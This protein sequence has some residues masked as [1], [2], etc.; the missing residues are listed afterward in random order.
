MKTAW[1]SGL[2]LLPVV[3]EGDDI[4][5]FPCFHRFILIF[6]LYILPYSPSIGVQVQR[7]VGEWRT[8]SPSSIALVRACV[9]ACAC[10]C[11]VAKENWFSLAQR[12]GFCL[13]E[14]SGKLRGYGMRR[15]NELGVVGLSSIRHEGGGQSSHGLHVRGKDSLSLCRTK[16]VKSVLVN[17]DIPDKN[18]GISRREGISL[19][20]RG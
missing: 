3:T 11:A 17:P 10:S 16:G 20:F 15:L 4:I 8:P 1:S 19:R 9:R 2:S 13:A 6:F 18:L 14:V 7:K 12:Q 5:L